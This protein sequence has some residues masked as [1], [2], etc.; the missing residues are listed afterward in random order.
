MLSSDLVGMQNRLFSVFMTLTIAPPLI[1]QLQPRFLNLRRIFTTRESASKL[2]KWPALAVAAFVVEVPWS[3]LFGTIFYFCW[4]WGVGFPRQT[5]T[6]AYVWLMCMAFE[7]FLVS[8]GQMLA[9]ISPNAIFAS[10]LIPA[11]FSFVIAFCGVLAPPPAMPYFWRSWMYCTS[12]LSNA[13]AGLTPFHYLLEGIV[14]AVVHDQPVICTETEFARIVPPRGET[15]QQW[16][17]PYINQMGGYLQDPLNTTLCE[18]CRFAN[19]DQYVSHHCNALNSG[20]INRRVL[21]AS[22]ERLWNI[23]VST[24]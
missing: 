4:Y 23:H 1:Q 8:F 5:S 16:I 3:L 20:C 11:F 12:L 17:G 2:Y 6:A 24:L 22:L 19:G 21:L 9:S 15:C 14:S 18:F 7:M 13:H 10:I